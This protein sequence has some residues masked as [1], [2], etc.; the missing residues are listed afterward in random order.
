MYNKSILII[1]DTP[2]ILQLT[3]TIFERA[4]YTR[5]LTA[6]SGQEA[7]KLLGGTCPDLFIL[8]VMMPGPMDGFAILQEIRAVSNVP[9]LM[10]TAKGESSDRVAGFELGADDYLVKPFVPRELL[11]RVQALLRRAYP[12]SNSILYLDYATVDF[13]TC[14]VVRPDKTVLLTNKEY[15]ILQKLAENA[16]HIVT[17]GALAQYVCGDGWSGYEST[18]MTHIRHLREKI[19]KDP[20]HPVSLLTIRGLGYKLVLREN[21]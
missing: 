15:C 19:E 10:L 4:G 16:D 12:S 17:I 20:S 13:S 2:D 14:E 18:L 3:R 1:D 21:P 6:S 8:D 5:V 7:Q 11:L 9:V